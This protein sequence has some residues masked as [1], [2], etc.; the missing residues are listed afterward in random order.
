VRSRAAPVGISLAFAFAFTPAVARAGGSD[1]VHPL[2]HDVA[3]DVAVTATAFALAIGAELG[4]AD[5]AAAECRWCQVGGLDRSARDALRWRSPESAARVSDFTGLALAPLSAFGTLA[6]SGFD[7]GAGRSAGV[8]ALLLAEALSL[9]ALANQVVKL[10]F[11]RERPFVHALAP[12]D[13]ARTKH[14]ADNNLSFYSGHT[15]A[16]MTLATAGGTLA[17]L[18]G[19]RL[20]PLVWGS[21]LA[22][23]ALTGYLRI[24]ADKHY[25]T[26]VLAGALIGASI[27]VLVP[28]VFHGRED[29][30]APG[31][32]A[33]APISPAGMATLGG[34][35]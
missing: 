32:S 28:L 30:P 16:T 20:A 4:K 7:A 19:Y 10:S 3:V 31:T 2:R 13:K 15:D 8:D 11:G 35:F 33:N 27:G 25:L 1:Q 21:G 29:A 23:S 22:I 26:D 12:A 6:A 34:S 24:A 18:R 5:L 9:S 17:S 14:T